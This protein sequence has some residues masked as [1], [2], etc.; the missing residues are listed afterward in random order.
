ME[1]SSILKALSHCIQNKFKITYLCPLSVPTVLQL[2]LLLLDI[3]GI[4]DKNVFRLINSN[5]NGNHIL[6]IFRLIHFESLNHV[7]K[8]TVLFSMLICDFLLQQQQQKD[9]FLETTQH[10]SLTS[11]SACK[12]LLC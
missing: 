4:G 12:T 2:V 1:K 3:P 5:D 9:G 6:T 8:E 11:K 7:L 10:V